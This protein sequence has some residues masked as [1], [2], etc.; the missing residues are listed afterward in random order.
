MNRDEWLRRYRAR[1]LECEPSL[2]KEELEEVAGI[3]AHEALSAE[4]PNNPEQAVDD[5]RECE[6]HEAQRARQVTV[7]AS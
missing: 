7:A 4:Y 3:E 6:G 1:L 2:S 5:E